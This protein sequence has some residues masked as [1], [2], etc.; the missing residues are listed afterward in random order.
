[1]FGEEVK[2][3]EKEE[4][5][6][7]ENKNN[8]ED[9]IEK[10]IDLSQLSITEY[11]YLVSIDNNKNVIFDTKEKAMKY[12]NIYSSKYTNNENCYLY[13]VVKDCFN[14]VDENTDIYKI[15]KSSN[16]YLISYD[17]HISTI[18]IIKTPKLN[19]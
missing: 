10:E 14:T 15:M 5:K 1:M 2:K 12:V 6:K 19:I 9:N 17:T 8:K 16:I 18:K 11:L 7:E 3:E 13:Y 4:V